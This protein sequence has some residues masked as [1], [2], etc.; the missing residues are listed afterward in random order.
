M[1]CTLCEKRV[2]VQYEVILSSKAGGI[3]CSYN[4]LIVF[5]V[6]QQS[7]L[8]KIFHCVYLVKKY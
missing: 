4:L 3:S 7:M 5:I 6:P 2:G 1:C 8:K